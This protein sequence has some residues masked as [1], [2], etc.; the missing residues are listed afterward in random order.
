MHL[1]QCNSFS[2]TRI[3]CIHDITIFWN[4]DLQQPFFCSPYC[5]ILGICWQLHL[6]YQGNKYCFFLVFLVLDW[7]YLVSHQLWWQFHQYLKAFFHKCVLVNN[8]W[9]WKIVHPQFGQSGFPRMIAPCVWWCQLLWHH[10]P[11]FSFVFIFT[12]VQDWLQV[13]FTYYFIYGRVI[14]HFHI[15]SYLT[16]LC[17]FWWLFTNEDTLWRLS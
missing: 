4:Q 9:D 1:L 15:T 11:F 3:C 2:V 17:L 7:Q 13:L 14:W 10:S 5:C 12:Y 16:E 8:W 6:K